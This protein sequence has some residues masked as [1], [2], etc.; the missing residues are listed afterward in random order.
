[1]GLLIVLSTCTNIVTRVQQGKSILIWVP[2]ERQILDLAKLILSADQINLYQSVHL[3]DLKAVS[4]V[5]VI[6]IIGVYHKYSR[7]D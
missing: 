7:I 1:M 2:S 6:C 4:V 5:G 3:N